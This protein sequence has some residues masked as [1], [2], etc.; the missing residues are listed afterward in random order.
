QNILDKKAVNNFWTAIIHEA[1]RLQP[2]CLLASADMFHTRTHAG[3][4]PYPLWHAATRRDLLDQDGVP[5][6]DSE[7]GNQYMTWEANAMFSG[8]WFWNGDHVKPVNAMVEHYYITVGR[9]ANF[10]P[11]F[12]PDKRGL[13]PDKVLDYATQFGDRTSRRFDKPVASTSGKGNLVELN[14]P[15]R[16][17]IDHVITMEELRE[18]QKIAAYVIEYRSNDQWKI[19]VEGKSVGHKRID[20]FPPVHAD[21]IRFRCLERFAEPVVVRSLSAYETQNENESSEY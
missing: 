21:A 7:N 18:G 19:L 15:E 17:A 1:R 16:H 9:G 4:A 13:M 3:K 6:Q 10:L 2:R 20:R 8:G 12:A 11:N 5:V 14:F